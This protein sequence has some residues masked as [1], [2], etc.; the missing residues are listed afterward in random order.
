[1][2][3]GWWILI[4]AAATGLLL[5]LVFGIN[6]RGER[7]Y[8]HE[9][10][11][12]RRLID[13][14]EQQELREL[15]FADELIEKIDE[16]FRPLAQMLRQGYRPSVSESEVEVITSGARKYDLLMQDLRNAKESIHI[17]YFHFGMDKGSRAVRRMLIRKAREGVKVRFIN[18]NIA[19]FPIPN[20]YFHRMEKAGVEVR[21]FTRTGLSV[22][23]FLL[24]VSYRDHRKI[25]VID[26]KIG[27]TGGMNIND[28]YFLQWRDTHLRLTGN[29][30]ASLQY[31]FLDRWFTISGKLQES[32]SSFFPMLNTSNHEPEEQLSAGSSVQDIAQPSVEGAVLTQITPDEPTSPSPVLLKAY[33]WIIDHAETYVWLQSPYLAPPDSLLQA[34]RRAVDRGVDVTVMLPERCDTAVM[35][36]LN[37]VYQEVC[38]EAGIKILLRS[39]EFI[40]S[41]TIVADD[42]LSCIG[43]TNLDNRSFGIDFEIDTFFYDRRLALHNKSI[44]LR[45]AQQS[46]EFTTQQAHRRN[47]LSRFL[48]RLTLPL[49]P[50]V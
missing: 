30:V 39:G 4:A 45:D 24:S 44:F 22:L 29:A 38:V 16:R 23:R 37:R 43:T 41:K 50:I 35:R 36:P 28:H 8:A 20:R 26:G 2:S 5:W 27:Y 19:N 40:H 33:E 47:R 46:A 18:E 6:W 3:V 34:M 10:E 9:H 15:L 11:Q 25:V 32:L 31:T 42:Y 13:M 49:T 1:M 17:E 48:D 14:P 21:D 7:I 12:M